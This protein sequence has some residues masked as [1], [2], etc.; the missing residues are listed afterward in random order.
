MCA[1]A[2]GKHE[3][4]VKFLFESGAELPS[5]N[6]APSL[7][8]GFALFLLRS[9]DPRLE[10]FLQRHDKRVVYS[11]SF[12]QAIQ[13]DDEDVVL[14]LLRFGADIDYAG[15]LDPALIHAIRKGD[16]AVVKLL[17]SHGANPNTRGWDS[18]PVTEAYSVSHP[19]A[20]ASTRERS[21]PQA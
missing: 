11:E 9:G 20:Q 5:G 14:R 7:L 2:Y 13:Q 3:E 19:Y 17:L 18:S 16:L 15:G 6:I 4:V 1:A 8:G 12:L 10:P 21:R